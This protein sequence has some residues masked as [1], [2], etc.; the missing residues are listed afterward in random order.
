MMKN[1]WLILTLALSAQLTAQAPS[2]TPPE[3][4]SR[5]LLNSERIAQ[6]FGS[7]GIAILESDDSVRVSN[8]YSLHGQTKICRTYAV[9]HYLYDIDAEVS[10][11]HSAILSGQS[12]GAVFTRRGWAIEKVNRYFGELPASGKVAD[13]MGG[14]VLQPLAAHIYDLVVSREGISLTYATIAEIHHPDYLSIMEL[15]GLYG[16]VST[17]AVDTDAARE[18]MLVLISQKMN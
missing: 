16:E 4:V 17:A 11:E 1:R 13:L 15:R 18:P 14:I 10:A 5:P 2:T 6:E 8:L 3:V 9:V 7:Y 12:I